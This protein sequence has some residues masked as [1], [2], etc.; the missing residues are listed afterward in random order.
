MPIKSK[1]RT[2]PDHPQKGIMFRDIT[3]LIKDAVGFRLVIDTLTQR[4]LKGDVEF[5]I[6]VGIESRGFIIGGALAY[7]LGRGFVPVRKKGKLPAETV[8]YEYEL[9]YGTDTVEIHKDAIKK[10]TRVLLIDDLL[11][12]GGTAAASAALIEKLGGKVT[13]MAF[14]VNLPDVGGAKKLTEKGYRFFCLTEF[15]GD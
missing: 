1:I 5:D 4:Y 7:T 8:S 15:E 12:T 9:E 13:E 6:I 10:G 3:T 14:I 2:I 11:A